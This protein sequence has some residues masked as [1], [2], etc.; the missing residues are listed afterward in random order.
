MLK[1]SESG[2]LSGLMMSL[3]SDNVPSTELDRVIGGVGD[4]EK[5]GSEKDLKA[6]IMS[7]SYIYSR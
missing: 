7:R 6:W 1:N 3:I 4:G 5:T 2:G